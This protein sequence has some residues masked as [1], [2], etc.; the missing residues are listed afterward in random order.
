[1]WKFIVALLIL[2]GIQVDHFHPLLEEAHQIL[3][4][5]VIIESSR[6]FRLGDPGSCENDVP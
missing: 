6:M 4:R 3:D 2:L 1:M 5:G